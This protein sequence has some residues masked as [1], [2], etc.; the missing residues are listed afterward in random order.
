MEVLNVSIE[1]ETL[2]FERVELF[3][4]EGIYSDIFSKKK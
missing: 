4:N 1:N 2:P 3:F